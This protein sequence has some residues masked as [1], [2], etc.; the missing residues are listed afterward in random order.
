MHLIVQHFNLTNLAEKFGQL[1][2]PT[3]VSGDNNKTPS[4]IDYIFG[5]RNLCNR[6]LEFKVSDLYKEYYSSD[7][8][9][10]I[11]ALDHPNGYV[12]SHDNNRFSKNRNNSLEQNEH[13]N[14][15]NLSAD[16]WNR[17]Q[18]F[19]NTVPMQIMNTLKNLVTHNNLSIHV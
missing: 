17:F 1:R 13:F 4:V 11:I 6:I 14:T 15:Q 8:N 5:S 10:L 7:H 2:T 9:I 3:F 18:L 12:K 16:Q 19:L